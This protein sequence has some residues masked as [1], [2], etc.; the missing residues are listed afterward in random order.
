MT[1]LLSRDAPGFFFWGVEVG[2]LFPGVLELLSC[3]ALPLAG[4]SSALSDSELLL[5][6][7]ESSSRLPASVGAVGPGR[8]VGAGPAP[9]LGGPVAGPEAALTW[10]FSPGG[11]A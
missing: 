11:L 5:L 3:T 10:E 2:A 9:L 8:P 1:S 7:S 4:A 6:L